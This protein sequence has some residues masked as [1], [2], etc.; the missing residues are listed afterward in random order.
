MVAAT[1]KYLLFLVH[2]RIFC[3]APW[4]RCC[5]IDPPEAPRKRGFCVKPTAPPPCPCSVV[6]SRV[7]IHCRPFAERRALTSL[8]MARVPPDCLYTHRNVRVGTSQAACPTRLILIALPLTQ[9]A[10]P[11]KRSSFGLMARRQP[12]ASEC[13]LRSPIGT[14]Q[15]G[16]P[17]VLVINSVERTSPDFRDLKEQ[18][19]TMSCVFRGSGVWDT[20]WLRVSHGIANPPLGLPEPLR[21]LLA[22]GGPGVPTGLATPASPHA[23][24]VSSQHGGCLPQGKWSER[25]SPRE[26]EHR[27]QPQALYPN[28]RSNTASLPPQATGQTPAPLQLPAPTHTGR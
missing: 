24:S 18:T 22:G 5:C 13:G 21:E 28:P 20:F 27:R 15:S 2:L 11:P 16:Y 4:A 3:R 8:P 26:R 9:D 14:N 6:T 23:A 7:C 10:L 17:G 12:S 25:E 19:F 1:P